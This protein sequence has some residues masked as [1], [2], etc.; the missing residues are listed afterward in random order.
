VGFCYDLQSTGN[1]YT[2]S[3]DWSRTNLTKKK[4]GG[5]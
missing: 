5:R 3:Q 1:N 4:R 2:F